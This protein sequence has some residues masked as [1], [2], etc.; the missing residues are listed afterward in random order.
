[1]KKLILA[2]ILVLNLTAITIEEISPEQNITIIGAVRDS[3][4]KHKN[5]P[6]YIKNQVE[7]N[8]KYNP[9]D[10]YTVYVGGIDIPST[11]IDLLDSKDG[12]FNLAIENLLQQDE[13]YILN[14]LSDIDKLKAEKGQKNL[15]TALIDLEH[16]YLYD[17]LHRSESAKRVA[18]HW[19]SED[20]KMG[21]CNLTI[22]K[23]CPPGTKPDN[24][25]KQCT[26]AVKSSNNKCPRDSTKTKTSASECIETH[27]K[28]CPKGFV[29]NNNNSC[30]QIK[31]CSKSESMIP[32]GPNAGMCK[33]K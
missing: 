13:S 28:N 32:K 21:E 3:I 23:K 15:H 4:I 20:C 17:T 29:E 19:P 8:L 5:A 14:A 33:N 31:K 1:M 27:K 16:T 25:T 22:N 12:S 18:L 24:N 11:P 9:Q 10:P 30:N 7:L 26:K 2:L 6:L